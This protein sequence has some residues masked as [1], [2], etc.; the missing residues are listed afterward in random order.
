MG[1]LEHE[2][3]NILEV[4]S[5]TFP[6]KWSTG[7][8]NMKDA[9]IFS[10]QHE[11]SKDL[12]TFEEITQLERSLSE[13]Q[14]PLSMRLPQTKKFHAPKEQICPNTLNL[15]NVAI[16]EHDPKYL[17]C[18]D[19]HFG[20]YHPKATHEKFNYVDRIFT[21]FTPNKIQENQDT[22]KLRIEYLGQTSE[23]SR[24]KLEEP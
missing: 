24:V 16:Q 9:L 18:K 20:R 2:L 7:F 17:S 11:P 5:N 8:S 6:R 4:E 14:N 22:R 15:R 1:G 10:K 12:G 23:D 19:S 21:L 3:P 13:T